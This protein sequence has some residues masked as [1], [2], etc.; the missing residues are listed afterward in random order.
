MRINASRVQRVYRW[1]E[2][3]GDAAADKKGL[4]QR[5]LCEAEKKPSNPGLRAFGSFKVKFEK[6]AGVHYGACQ[7]AFK[8]QNQANFGGAPRVLW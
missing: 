6:F 2:K 7:I 4:E 5:Y 3:R 8:L 1:V